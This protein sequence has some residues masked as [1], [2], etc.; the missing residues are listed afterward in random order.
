VTSPTS[1]RTA[2]RPRKTRPAVARP[3]RRPSRRLR[4]VLSAVAGVVLLGDLN[5]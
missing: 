3:D 2:A 4:Q 5:S 1:I